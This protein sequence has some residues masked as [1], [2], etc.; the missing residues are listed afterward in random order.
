MR[1]GCLHR[2]A[3]HREH[4]GVAQS[5]VYEGKTALAGPVGGAE[6][7]GYIIADRL[8]F[9]RV[10]DENVCGAVNSAHGAPLGR[11]LAVSLDLAAVGITRK[12][13]GCPACRVSDE[14]ARADQHLLP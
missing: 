7:F 9:L 11:R 2:S 10:C 8:R 5:I 4:C 1:I 3:E 14:C 6:A 12:G 13:T